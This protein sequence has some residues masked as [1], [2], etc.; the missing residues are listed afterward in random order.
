MKSLAKFVSPVLFFT[1]IWVTQYLSALDH[2]VDLE[3]HVQLQQELS[4]LIADYVKKNLP[5]MQNFQMLSI[6]TKSS[7]NG[8]VLAFFNYSFETPTKNQ[9]QVA[10]TQLFG[11]ATLQRIKKE[12]T[13]EWTLNAINMEGENVTFT[14]PL[15]IT[16]SQDL[17][18]EQLQNEKDHS[19]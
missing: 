17:P 15:V 16:P 4:S 1:L 14:E 7:L 19:K 3:Q 18:D 10:V 8:K 12:P 11:Q 6:Y 13:P 2:D 5:E 9:N